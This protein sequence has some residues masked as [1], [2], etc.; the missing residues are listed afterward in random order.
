[1]SKTTFVNGTM[2]DHGDAEVTIDGVAYALVKSITFKDKM[3]IGKARGTS[4]AVRGTTTG[5]YDADGDIEFY[6]GAAGEG[7]SID[8]LA[9]LGNGW[10]KRKNIP[11]VVTRGKGDQPLRVDELVACRLLGRESSSSEGNEADT[12]KFGLFISK[13]IANGI[14]PIDA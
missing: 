12:N 10:M 14:D 6:P 2:Y 3:E 5:T 9:K 8:L 13:I 4:A 1:M 11:I 7:G